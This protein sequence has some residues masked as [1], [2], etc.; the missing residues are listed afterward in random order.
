VV[1][2]A[3]AGFASLAAG[4]TPAV[5]SL[6]ATKILGTGEGGLVISRDR[7]TVDRVRTASNFGFDASRQATIG[8]TNAKMSEYH[9]ALGHAALDAWDED[10]AAWMAAARVYA[11]A[12][13]PSNRVRLQA[14]FGQEWV[15]S[16][17]VLHTP[18]SSALRIEAALTQAGIETRRWWGKG[19][20]AQAATAHFPRSHLPATEALIDST[21]AVPFYRDIDRADIRRIAGIVLNA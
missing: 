10:L 15:S 20:H 4:D 8:A 1:I 12:I 21:I 14:G 9:A 11:D 7:S 5:V 16:T 18:D 6:H 3:A 19:A 17:C 2:D 13:A